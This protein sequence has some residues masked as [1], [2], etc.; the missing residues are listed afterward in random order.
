[1]DQTWCLLF[2]F[3][4]FLNLGTELESIKLHKP[5]EIRTQGN[6]KGLRREIH[7]AMVAPTKAPF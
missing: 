3:C 5:V 2:Y 1:M 6:Q 4:S 7:C